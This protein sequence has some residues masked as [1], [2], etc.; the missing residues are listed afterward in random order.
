MD[1]CKVLAVRS[2]GGL[3][4]LVLRPEG[5]AIIC[6]ASHGAKIRPGSEQIFLCTTV[7]RIE[8][9]W[10]PGRSDWR[11]PSIPTLTITILTAKHGATL[12]AP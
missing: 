11:H 4:R 2:M 7:L 6:R 3:L 9:R 10:D 8:L 5:L 12:R 1:G